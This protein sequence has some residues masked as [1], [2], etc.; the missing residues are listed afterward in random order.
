MQYMRVVHPIYFYFLC[1]FLFFYWCR[2]H[3]ASTVRRCEGSGLECNKRAD[4]PE[5]GEGRG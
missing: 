5:E 1:C 3:V 4:P 2:V